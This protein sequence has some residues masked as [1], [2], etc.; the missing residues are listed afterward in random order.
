MLWVS[1]VVMLLACYIQ[2]PEFEISIILGAA[3]E[4]ERNKQNVQQNHAQ[5]TWCLHLWLWHNEH[6]M[7]IMLFIVQHCCCYLLFVVIC[8]RILYDIQQANVIYAMFS[9]VVVKLNAMT[10]VL[11]NFFSLFFSFSTLGSVTFEWASTW[12]WCV[13]RIILYANFIGNKCNQSQIPNSFR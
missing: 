11:F 13:T 4:R 3:K 1:L 12:E 10:Y 5:Q 6:D 7:K 9:N 2:Y 8:L